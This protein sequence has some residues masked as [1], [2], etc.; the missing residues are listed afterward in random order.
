MERKWI[1]AGLTLIMLAIVLGA[2]GAHGLKK[3]TSDTDLLAAFDTGTKYQFLQGLG[4]LVV[5]FILQKFELS[6]KFLFS[7]FFGGILLFSGSIYLL[8]LAK[9]YQLDWLRIPMIPLTPIGGA[10]MI[11]G[12]CILLFRFI[13]KK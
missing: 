10:G 3:I 5:P 9:I 2:F 4:L 11:L 1:T 7:A 12:W 8:S 13:Q 6:A